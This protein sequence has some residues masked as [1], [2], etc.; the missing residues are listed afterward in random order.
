L[1]QAPFAL[2]SLYHACQQDLSLNTINIEKSEYLLLHKSFLYSKL[3]I[4][5]FE[6]ACFIKALQ[7]ALPLAQAIPESDHFDLGQ[8]LAKLIEWQLITNLTLTT[9]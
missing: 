7:N 5:S 9:I 3:D 6:E 4:I 2:G 8:T 1:L